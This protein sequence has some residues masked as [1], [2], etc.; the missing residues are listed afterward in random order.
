M[1][2]QRKNGSKGKRRKSS[3]KNERLIKIALIIVVII[4]AFIVYKIFDILILS[5]ER[6]DLS[7]GTYYQ[8]FY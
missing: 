7:G 8:Y 5:N 6:Y 2:Q 4:F 1:K 3:N